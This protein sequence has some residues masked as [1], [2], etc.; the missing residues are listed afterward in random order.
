[1]CSASRAR[2]A[3]ALSLPIHAV[4]ALCTVVRANCLCLHSLYLHC[5]HIDSST[6]V[7]LL[8][9]V[10]APKISVAAL[11]SLT[12]LRALAICRDDRLAALSRPAQFICC[13]GRICASLSPCALG[14]SS[15]H[16][17]NTF[18]AHELSAHVFYAY[19]E[20]IKTFDMLRSSERTPLSRVLL[21]YVKHIHNFSYTNHISCNISENVIQETYR[22]SPPIKTSPLKCG[23][24]KSQTPRPTDRHSPYYSGQQRT[25]GK[26]TVLNTYCRP[27]SR[28]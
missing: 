4:P 17:P 20:L 13:A 28:S 9:T 12:A 26:P 18:C 14:V 24:T 8:A 11:P 7:Q 1:M 2:H 19:T 10:S 3:T 16:P 15:S 21:L 27:P 23:H 25:T 6:V 5:A 22:I